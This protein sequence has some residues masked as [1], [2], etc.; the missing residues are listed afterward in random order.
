MYACKE[1]NKMDQS[2]KVKANIRVLIFIVSLPF[3]VLLAVEAY[4]LW[5][6]DPYKFDITHILVTAMIYVFIRTVVL[7]R[8]PTGA[9]YT[10]KK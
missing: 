8:H 3:W 6:G 5:L 10:S 2:D 4:S 1:A 7:G 9:A